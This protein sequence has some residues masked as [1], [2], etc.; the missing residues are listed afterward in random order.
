VVRD[1]ENDPNRLNPVVEV[2]CEVL[3]EIAG[4]ASASSASAW[5]SA[6]EYFLNVSRQVDAAAGI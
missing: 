2:L 6:G 4:W 5:D 3:S 1:L